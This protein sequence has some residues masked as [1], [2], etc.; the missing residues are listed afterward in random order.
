VLYPLSY[1]RASRNLYL[2]ILSER[3]EEI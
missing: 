3:Q 1:G 2:F